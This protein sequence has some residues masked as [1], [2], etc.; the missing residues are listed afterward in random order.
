MR[1][2]FVVSGPSFQQGRLRGDLT[3]FFSY[4]TSHSVEERTFYIASL[5]RTENSGKKTDFR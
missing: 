2:M 1:E 3:G 5:G 4:L